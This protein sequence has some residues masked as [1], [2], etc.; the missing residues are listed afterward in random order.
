MSTEGM[1]GRATA[2]RERLMARLE[3]KEQEIAKIKAELEH[4]DFTINFIGSAPAAAAPAKAKPGRRKAV[5]AKKAGAKKAPAKKASSKKV[6]GAP[7]TSPFDM[8]KPDPVTFVE[9]TMAI[10]KH[11]KEPVHIDKLVEQFLF[12]GKETNKAKLANNLRAH[13]GKGTKSL[14]KG[15]WTLASGK[16]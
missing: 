1:M 10:M 2:E 14:G 6:K 5:R 15:M 3:S 11:A 16:K 9:S 12:W 8:P 4:L 7:A 13:P